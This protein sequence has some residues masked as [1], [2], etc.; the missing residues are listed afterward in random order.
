MWIFPTHVNE[1]QIVSLDILGQQWIFINSLVLANFHLETVFGFT[2][3]TYNNS[4]ATANKVSVNA[5]SPL[6]KFT[7]SCI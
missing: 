7:F 2:A 4:T 5:M 6:L 3:R 1:V